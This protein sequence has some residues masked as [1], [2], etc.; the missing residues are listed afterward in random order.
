ME[1][2]IVPLTKE[3]P[4]NRA[5]TIISVVRTTTLW[6]CEFIRLVHTLLLLCCDDE[7]LSVS[8]ANFSKIYFDGITKAQKNNI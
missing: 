8:L 2:V 3:W 1:E 7:S 4:Q 6:Q 5:K